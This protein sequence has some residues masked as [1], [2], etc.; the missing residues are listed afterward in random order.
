MR[1][2]WIKTELL[3]PID[4]GG[5]IRTYQMLR[6]LAHHHHVTYLALD[7]GQ[8]APDALA[9]AKEYAQE[10]VVVPFQPAAKLSPAFFADL[11]RNL[12]SPLPYAI[13]RYRSPQLREQIQRL[14]S[15]ADLIVCDFLTPSLNVPDGLPVIL[16]QHNVE[17][18]IWQRHAAV[19]QNPLRRAY[20]RVQWRRMLRHEAAGRRRVLPL[21]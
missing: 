8:A 6:S 4:K 13:A 18:M 15:A 3:H 2:L 14:G 5:R 12:F 9:R 11:L 16:F 19:A 7:D 21:V 1:I 17:A 10:V 20:M